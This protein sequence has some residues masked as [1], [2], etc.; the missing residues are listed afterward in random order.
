MKSLISLLSLFILTGCSDINTTFDPNYFI[1]ECQKLQK[2]SQEYEI[3]VYRNSVSCELTLKYK[4]ATYIFP[5]HNYEITG[6]G[7]ILD[8]QKELKLKPCLEQNKCTSKSLHS[9]ILCYNKCEKE[10]N[11][12][13]N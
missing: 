4:G 3:K 10:L 11:E 6:A 7:K 13:S 12:K 5:F 1:K 9:R 8:Y 2:I